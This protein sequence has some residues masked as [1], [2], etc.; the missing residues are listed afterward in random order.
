MVDDVGITVNG[1]NDRGWREQ[2]RSTV[3]AILGRN[4]RCVRINGDSENELT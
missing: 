3:S 4:G 1:L 2:V